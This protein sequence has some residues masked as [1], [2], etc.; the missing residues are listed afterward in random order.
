MNI[1]NL[2]KVLLFYMVGSVVALLVMSL[3]IVW[4]VIVDVTGYV[5]K[6]FK[7]NFD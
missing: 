3:V 6:K 4:C 2:I 1:I 7:K 5:L